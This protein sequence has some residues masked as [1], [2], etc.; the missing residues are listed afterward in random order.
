MSS[1]GLCEHGHEPSGSVKKAGYCLTGWVTIS[2]SKNIVHHGVSIIILG[3]NIRL[4]TLFSYPLN[5]FFPECEGPQHRHVN[6]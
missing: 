3:P 4:S 2:F 1:G 5:V 6:S